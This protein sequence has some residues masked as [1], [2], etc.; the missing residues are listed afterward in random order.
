MSH[1]QVCVSDTTKLAIHGLSRV[2]QTSSKVAKFTIRLQGLDT[3]L[4]TISKD[5]TV[6]RHKT[7]H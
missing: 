1:G 3:S 7:R 2:L 6:S 4:N 5:L